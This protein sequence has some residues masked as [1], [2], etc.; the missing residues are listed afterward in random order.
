MPTTPT[1]TMLLCSGMYQNQPVLALDLQHERGPFVPAVIAI[2]PF[3]VGPQGRL[4]Q[5][6][7]PFAQ[8]EAVEQHRTLAA[9]IDDHLART[10]SLL[11]GFILD[12]HADGPVAFEQHFQHAHPF[13]DIARPARG[14]C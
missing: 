2:G 9:G 11:A 4:L 12:A 10:V 7:I 14:R 3:P 1:L 8:L 5:E 6:R 13:E